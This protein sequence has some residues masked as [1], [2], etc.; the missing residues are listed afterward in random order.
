M[1]NK[2][3]S[4]LNTFIHNK[5]NALTVRSHLPF[6]NMYKNLLRNSQQK[7]SYRANHDLNPRD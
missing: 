2:K 1:S 4:A 7:V 6:R 3:K 5:E